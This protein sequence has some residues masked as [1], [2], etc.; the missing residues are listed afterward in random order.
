MGADGRLDDVLDALAR[1]T[2]SAMSAASDDEHER[3][4]VYLAACGRSQC[5]DLLLSAVALEPDSSVASGI[6]L[7]MPAGLTQN[8]ASVERGTS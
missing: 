6:V 5:R 4:P 3:W 8:L 1:C 7:R 2:G